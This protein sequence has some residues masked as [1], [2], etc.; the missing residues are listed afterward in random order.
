MHE[1]V[2]VQ[3]WRRRATWHDSW[4]VRLTV[5]FGCD[6]QSPDAQATCT[7][8]FADREDARREDPVDTVQAPRR[9]AKGRSS[10]CG[11]IRVV[12]KDMRGA[13]AA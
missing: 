2:A 9:R 6:E 4:G 13:R 3:R 7:S 10:E 8:A 1:S 11:R 5:V 12:S